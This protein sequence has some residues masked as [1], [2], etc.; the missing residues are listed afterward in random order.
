TAYDQPGAGGK[1][2]AMAEV[3]AQLRELLTLAE[4]LAQSADAS[5]ASPADTSAQKAI[6]DALN[7]LNKP[8]VLVSA[9]GPVGVVSGDGIELGSD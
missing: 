6:N 7:E 8:G 3:V 4:S 1:Q 2:L 5:K 9:P